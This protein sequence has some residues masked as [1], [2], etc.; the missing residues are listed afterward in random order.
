MK[1]SAIRNY[2]A[3]TR[4]SVV[5]AVAI[6]F[7]IIAIIQCWIVFRA[8]L[9]Y[10]TMYFLCTVYVLEMF[11]DFSVAP[12]IHNAII[13]CRFKY[14]CKYRLQVF[15]LL[16]SKWIFKGFIKRIECL[17]HNTRSYS[18]YSLINYAEKY[19]D[20]IWIHMHPNKR[21]HTH[22]HSAKSTYLCAVIFCVY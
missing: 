13:T 16:T 17:H 4:T 18:L 5:V 8:L 11:R 19:T 15:F 20:S 12:A 3:S 21:I 14:R 2:I 1:H 9:F 7:D 6:D 22:T 10:G